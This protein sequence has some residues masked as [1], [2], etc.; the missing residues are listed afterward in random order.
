MHGATIKI[1]SQQFIV[2]VHKSSTN[3]VDKKNKKNVRQSASAALHQYL[4]IV[5][6]REEIQRNESSLCISGSVIA[7]H[8]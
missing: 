8:T 7:I 3:S 4:A 1:V 5:M 6:H 2:S